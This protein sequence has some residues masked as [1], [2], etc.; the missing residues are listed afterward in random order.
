MIGARIE[1]MATDNTDESVEIRQHP[2][3]PY[4]N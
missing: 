3:D 4:T 2:F 1:R